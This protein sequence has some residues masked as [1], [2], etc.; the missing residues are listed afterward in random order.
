MTGLLRAAATG[1]AD[2]VELLLESGANGNHFDHLDR[3][4]VYLASMASSGRAR[5]MIQFVEDFTD[6]DGNHLEVRERLMP[7]QQAGPGGDGKKKTNFAKKYRH[8]GWV[9]KFRL[10]AK[11]P[12]MAVHSRFQKGCRFQ[13]QT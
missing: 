9:I 13:S 4:L 6:K 8:L 12:P 3:G 7:V 11:S 1:L 2:V 5:R 10:P